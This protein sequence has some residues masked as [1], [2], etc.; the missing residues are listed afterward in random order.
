VNAADQSTKSTAIIDLD[1]DRIRLNPKQPRK[2]FDDVKLDEL[3]ASIKRNG[4]LEPVIVRPVGGGYYEL[5]AGERR[6]RAA[7]QAGLTYIPAVSKALD[8]RQTLEI[9]LIENVQREDITALECADAYRRL[10]D[11]Y[12]M[13]QERVAETVGKSRSTIANTLRLLNLPTE[14]LASLGRDEMS[15]GH[16]RALLSIPDRSKQIALWRRIVKDGLSVR[17]AERLARSDSD[18]SATTQA[19][20]SRATLNTRR[21]DPNIVNVEDKLRRFLGTKVSINNLGGKGRIEIEFY[22]D[23]DLMRIIDLMAGI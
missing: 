22:D 23:E 1:V 14:I 6:F 15:E 12:G 20:V 10:I 19:H 18:S 17:T 2:F 9:G 13:T 3:S 11:D 5:V 21:L 16:A 8:D 4:V 7:V